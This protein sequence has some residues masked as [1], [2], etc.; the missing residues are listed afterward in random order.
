MWWS[1]VWAPVGGTVAAAVW[2]ASLWSEEPATLEAFVALLES[3]RF[4]G[5]SDTDM[6]PALFQESLRRQ[7]EITEGLGRQVREAVELLVDKLNRLDRDSG[8]TLLAGVS[9][10]DFYA[11]VVTVMMRV[12]RPAQCPSRPSVRSGFFGESTIFRRSSHVTQT[13]PPTP[14]HQRVSHSVT[15][16]G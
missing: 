16:R 13:R 11:G 15:P 9:D 1:L 6:L 5:V 7:E 2:D 8:R 12:V 10:E 4:L 14:Q 3:R